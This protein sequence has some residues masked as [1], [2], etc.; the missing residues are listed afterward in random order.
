MAMLDKLKQ[1]NLEQLSIKDYF[2]TFEVSLDESINVDELTNFFSSQPYSETIPYL[3]RRQ[4]KPIDKRFKQ[5]ELVYQDIHTIGAILWE[6][7]ISLSELID[8][9]GEP[10]IHNEPYSNTTAFA[11]KSKNKN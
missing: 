10:I 3:T 9:F 7:D 11:F 5:I 4:L 2:K 1:S 8:I 6:I